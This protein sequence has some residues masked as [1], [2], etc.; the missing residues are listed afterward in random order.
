MSKHLTQ[1]QFARSFVEGA[2]GAEWEHLTECSECQTELDRFGGT[3]SAL[4][5]AVRGRVDTH[6][7][8]QAFDL[9]VARHTPNT[10]WALTAAAILLFGIAPLLVE[11]PREAPEA[12]SAE[13]SPEAFMNAINLH[14][15]RT[16]PSPMEPM[17]SLIPRDIYL[18]EVGGAQ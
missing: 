16:T 10:R 9:P 18:A 4:R 6:I 1:E 11:R 13:A 14:L 17:L 8:T 2:S 7:A 12:S 5:L 15:S 3:V